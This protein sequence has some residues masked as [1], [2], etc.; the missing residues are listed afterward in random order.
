MFGPEVTRQERFFRLARPFTSTDV[1]VR[2]RKASLKWHPDQNPTQRERSQEL[3]V[4][5]VQKK[6]FLME[7]LKRYGGT[8]YPPQEE[9]IQEDDPFG[10]AEQFFTGHTYQERT[11]RDYYARSFTGELYGTKVV[12]LNALLKNNLLEI[13]DDLGLFYSP[14]DRKSVLVSRLQK[15]NWETLNGAFRQKHKNRIKR[16]LEI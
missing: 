1:R 2:F 16:R 10:F 3:F 9:N 8:L 4:K 5:I 6:N 15:E 11:R 13:H 7:L 12:V 14:S